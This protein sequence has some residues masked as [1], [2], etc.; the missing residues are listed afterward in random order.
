MHIGEVSYLEHMG[1]NKSGNIRL[2]ASLP[3]IL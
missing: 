1:D 2:L 3:P